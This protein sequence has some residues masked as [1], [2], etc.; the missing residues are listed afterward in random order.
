LIPSVE[1]ALNR[2][3]KR[4]EAYIRQQKSPLKRAFF[5]QKKQ[6]YKKRQKW[7]RGVTW[8][9]TWGVKSTAFTSQKNTP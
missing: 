5:V 8:G 3:N 9:V 4:K 1:V 7:H 2:V 6:L